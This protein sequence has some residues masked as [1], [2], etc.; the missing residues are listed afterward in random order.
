MHRKM[1][2]IALFSLHVFGC[3]KFLMIIHY[4]KIRTYL[5]LHQKNTI[6][7]YQLLLSI[8]QLG[9]HRFW[10]VWFSFYLNRAQGEQD[11]SSVLDI[12]SSPSTWNWIYHNNLL[13]IKNDFLANCRKNSMSISSEISQYGISIWCIIRYLQ[14]IS[15]RLGRWL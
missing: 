11:L 15:F 14:D 7:I 1:C 10:Q 5:T 13:C 6:F 9:K 12:T 3:S 8:V 4:D 2:I